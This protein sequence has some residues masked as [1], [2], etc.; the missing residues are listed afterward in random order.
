MKVNQEFYGNTQEGHLDIEKSKSA[1]SF[2]EVT[3][4]KLEFYTEA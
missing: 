2:Q 3:P 1:K 4:R